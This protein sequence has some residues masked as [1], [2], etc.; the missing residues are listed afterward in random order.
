MKVAIVITT[1]IFINS[2]ALARLIYDVSF[3]GGSFVPGEICPTGSP[4]SFPQYQEGLGYSSIENS[5][6]F[7]SQV[8]DLG[9][10]LFD[11]GMEF[12]SGIHS[13]SW[14]ALV[15]AHDPTT[16]WPG[17]VVMF[18]DSPVFVT[19][20]VLHIGSEQYLGVFSYGSVLEYEVLLDLDADTASFSMNGVQYLAAEPV[21]GIS[22]LGRVTM[23]HPANNNSWI[24]DFRWEVVPEPSSLLLLM[25]GGCI[26]IGLRS[27]L[28]EA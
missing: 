9:W 3:D 5:V 13:F 28:E 22:V 23:Q 4:P 25:C 2:I 15:D 11:P 1:C 21:P 8:A 26:L 6:L 16:G 20:G 14:S 12:S 24:D 17:V 19:D 10:L 18:G 7:G 27:R